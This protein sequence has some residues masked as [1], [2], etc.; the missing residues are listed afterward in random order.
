MTGVTLLAPAARP[1]A[2]TC[3]SGMERHY[4]HD[5]GRNRRRSPLPDGADRGQEFL[6][7]R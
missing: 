1:I 4:N 2:A 7:D 3:R 5:A 6:R